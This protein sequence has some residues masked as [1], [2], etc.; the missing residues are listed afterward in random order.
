M[1]R[2]LLLVGLMATTL[3]A[4]ALRLPNLA[5]RPMHADE[6]VNAHKFGQLLE[7]GDY[8]YDPQ[9]YHGPTLYYATLLSAR[10]TGVSTY[11]DTT[12]GMLRRVPAIAS[13]LM[14]AMLFL[15]IREL[16]PG[17]AIISA[18]LAAV[19]PAF[20]YYGRYY[21]H[22]SLL[23]CFTSGFILTMVRLWRSGYWP[24]A[25]L[26]GICLGLMHATKESFLIISFALLIA[27]GISFYL[28]PEQNAKPGRKNLFKNICIILLVATLVSITFYSSFFTHLE[29]VKDAFAAYGNYLHDLPQRTDHVHPWYY[30]LYLLTWN[31]SD[32]GIIWTEGFILISAVVGFIALVKKRAPF[33]HIVFLRFIAIYTLIVLIIYAAIPYKTPW[34]LLGFHWGLIIMAGTGWIALWRWLPSKIVRLAILLTLILGTGHLAWQAYAANFRYDCDPDNPYAYAPT[35]GDVDILMQRLGD[36]VKTSPEGYRLRMNIISADNYWPLPWY[37]RSFERVG[38]YNTMDEMNAPADIIIT[39]AAQDT[40][41]IDTLYRLQPAGRKSLYAP[42]FN[43]RLYLRPGVELHGYITQELQDRNHHRD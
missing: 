30:Y 40:A 42:L 6:A 14:V 28:T 24:W 3:I 21:I 13:L 26:A 11:Q 29:G 7:Q 32:T 16:S 10:L 25:I 2:G 31:S 22:E 37:L 38:W 23:V 1:K 35:S 39:T 20:V 18:L 12:A 5:H 15:V 17:V 34:C 9:E 27:G 19:S 41:I 33:A 43:Q 4:A 36:A 8:R